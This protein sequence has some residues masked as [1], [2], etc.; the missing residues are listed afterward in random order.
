MLILQKFSATSS[1]N[2]HSE[3]QRTLSTIFTD[4]SLK[5][6]KLWNKLRKGAGVCVLSVRVKGERSI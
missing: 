1:L 5:T 2:N 4:L 6:L 3:R